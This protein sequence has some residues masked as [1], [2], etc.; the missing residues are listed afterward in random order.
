MGK[1]LVSGA[2]GNVG[3]SV[4][5]YLITHTKKAEIVAGVFNREAEQ[6]N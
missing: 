2:S 6:K 5:K 3:K 1:I 4:I